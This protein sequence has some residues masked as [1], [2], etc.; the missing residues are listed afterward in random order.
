VNYAAIDERS[1]FPVPGQPDSGTRDT[2][3]GF[4]ALSLSNVIQI[5][6]QSGSI[7]PNRNA[8]GAP[9]LSSG[10][11]DTNTLLEE[12]GQ[13]DISNHNLHSAGGPLPTVGR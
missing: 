2:S 6:N 13:D 8:S 7:D 4:V 10:R 3:G 9:V 1:N 11:N 5:E 12:F